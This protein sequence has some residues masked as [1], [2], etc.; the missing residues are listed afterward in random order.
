[1]VVDRG[2]E[3]AARIVRAIVEC[4]QRVGSAYHR[5]AGP[6]ANPFLYVIF[7]VAQEI[8]V[9]GDNIENLCVRMTMDWN[10]DAGCQ[11]HLVETRAIGG[12]DAH[13]LPR[14]PSIAYLNRLP[15]LWSDLLHNIFICNNCLHFHFS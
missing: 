12:I 8:D 7:V 5:I 10:T 6:A 13:S 15:F 11:I 14:Q 4:V 2:T 3:E 9:S 1:M